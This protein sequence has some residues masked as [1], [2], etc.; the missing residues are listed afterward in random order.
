M[1]PPPRPGRGTHNIRTEFCSVAKTVW[2]CKRPLGS[3]LCHEV[4][5]LRYDSVLCE[6]I[7][8]RDTLDCPFRTLCI[9]S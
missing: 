9:A 4:E 5:Q 7:S 8:L 2:A 3:L 1:S 6:D